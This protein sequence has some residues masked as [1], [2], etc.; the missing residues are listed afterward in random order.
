MSVTTELRE[1][2]AALTPEQ[3]GLFEEAR[4]LI[5]KNAKRLLKRF[6]GLVSMAA[7]RSAGDLA[8]LLA[9]Q[10]YD[11]GR[12]VSFE[13]YA[14]DRITGAMLDEVRAES[15]AQ[16]LALA[17][18]RASTQAIGGQPDEFKVFDHGPIQAQK[19]VRAAAVASAA[20][21]FVQMQAARE[22]EARAEGSAEDELVRREAAARA[23]AALGG[24]RKGL[25]KDDAVV[26][27]LVYDEGRQLQEAAE[28]MGISI[29]TMYRRHSRM[30]K[31]LEVRLRAAG[32]DGVPVDR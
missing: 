19:G 23:G 20:A 16:K 3:K 5:E 22:A 13:T 9:A 12:G 1:G 32:V 24:A 10:R 30:L 26:L 7:L 2:L 6:A 14:Q 21:M 11:A 8:L 31:H 29:S 18:Y 15:R 25:A 17:F 4:H 28:V 27:R